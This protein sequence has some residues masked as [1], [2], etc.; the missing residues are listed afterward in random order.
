MINWM[1][2]GYLREKW[3]LL[4]AKWG[5]I[6]CCKSKLLAQLPNMWCLVAQILF[7]VAHN[8]QYAEGNRLFQ[9]ATA[10]W[11]LVVHKMLCSNG[12][13]AYSSADIGEQ[14]KVFHL[15]LDIYWP[16]N[17]LTLNIEKV[18]ISQ[19][20]TTCLNLHFINNYILTYLWSHFTN[21][22]L[23][24]MILKLKFLI[25]FKTWTVNFFLRVNHHQSGTMFIVIIYV[26]VNSDIDI[27]ST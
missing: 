17:I 21:E 12:L 10:I 7:F 4:T 6:Q 22:V 5:L 20:L 26:I 8:K 15:S 18:N 9:Y 3:G 24:M 14:L 2:R 11:S 23:T 1:L 25:F 27:F 16:C 19:W 13:S